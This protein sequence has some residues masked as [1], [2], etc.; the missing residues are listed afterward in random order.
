MTV[1]VIPSAPGGR[2]QARVHTLTATAA[3]RFQ[4]RFRAATME[5]RTIS[6]YGVIGETWD[7]DED[8]YYGMVGTT[9]TQI[10][11][12]L[13]KAGSGPVTINVNSPGGDMF[14]GLAIYNLLREHPGEVTVNVMGTAASAASVVTMAADKLRIAKAGFLMIHNTWLTY[15][16]NRNSFTA[17][18]D[19][20]LP[21]D[22]AMA[23]IYSDRTGIPVDAVL[24][25]MDAETWIS[26]EE[27]VA[28][29]FADEMLADGA[30][31]ETPKASVR[32]PQSHRASAEADQIS[33]DALSA[34][35][36]ATASLRL[37]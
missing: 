36:V 15:S 7:Y 19:Q 2:L 35:M 27:A 9:S 32:Q 3:E 21:F 34:L 8:G 26:G 29:G 22:K 6:I 30:A 28:Q 17:M 10:A 4:D 37:L 13:S 23:A 20:L 1:R 16:G 12:F 24:G 11:G 25:L 18:A 5:D 14:E 33:A 31:K